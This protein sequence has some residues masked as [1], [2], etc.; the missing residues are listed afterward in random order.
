M[1][2][3][4]VVLGNKYRWAQSALTEGGASLTGGPQDGP[5]VCG[6]HLRRPYAKEE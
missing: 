2:A 5:G 4:D 6:A 3:L 1:K